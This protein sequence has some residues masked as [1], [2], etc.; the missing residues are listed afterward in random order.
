M[1]LLTAGHAGIHSFLSVCHF[2]ASMSSAENNDIPEAA[3][4]QCHVHR[5]AKISTFMPYTKSPFQTQ[6]VST[7]PDQAWFVINDCGQPRHV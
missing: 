6:Q 4:I 5:L 7:E 1:S 3:A 2:A